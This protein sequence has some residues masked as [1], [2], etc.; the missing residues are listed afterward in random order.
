MKLTTN[1]IN[2]HYPHPMS[3]CPHFVQCSNQVTDLYETLHQFHLTL[4]LPQ[5]KFQNKN[6][7]NSFTY[8]N[9]LYTYLYVFTHKISS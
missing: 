8:Y 4:T 1:S 2:I 6:I 3:F 9:Q 5:H 7:Y